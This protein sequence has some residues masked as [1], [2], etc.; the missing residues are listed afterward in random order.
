MLSFCNDAFIYNASPNCTDCEALID[1]T[2]GRELKNGIRDLFWA[3]FEST[4]KRTECYCKCV[5]EVDWRIPLTF[6]TWQYW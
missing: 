4:P 6:W 1:H 3:D 2:L 5:R